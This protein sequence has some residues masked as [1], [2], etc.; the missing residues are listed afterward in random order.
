MTSRREANV[1]SLQRLQNPKGKTS[2]LMLTTSKELGML[3]RQ[4]G[5][6]SDTK[7]GLKVLKK[8]I[9]LANRSDLKDSNFVPSDDLLL[10]FVNIYCV[11][12]VFI[13]VKIFTN[14]NLESKILKKKIK[15]FPYSEITP[16]DWH[17]LFL[18]L[19][20]NIQ[21][22]TMRS[23]APLVLWKGDRTR[24]TVDIVVQI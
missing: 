14:K 15:I 6:N 9:I 11:G 13:M 17:A 10:F 7:S 3:N 4:K 2:F 5:S 16:A 18:S 19:L 23:N 8:V 22:S 20:V 12:K 21:I 24:V 1:E